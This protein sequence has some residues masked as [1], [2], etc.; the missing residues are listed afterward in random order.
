MSKLKE[1]YDVISNYRR[2]WFCRD[3]YCLRILSKSNLKIV[4]IE[5]GKDIKK[6]MF[7]RKI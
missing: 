2:C 6:D 4:I 7:C 3:I 5:K 1:Y